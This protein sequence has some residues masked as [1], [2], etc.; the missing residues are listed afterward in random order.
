MLSGKKRRRLRF[1][2]FT[3]YFAIFLAA[4]TL[5][6]AVFAFVLPLMMTST[7]EDEHKNKLYEYT[8]NVA[9][10]YQNNINDAS[11]DEAMLVYALNGTSEASGADV[12]I[13]DLKGNVIYCS[14]MTADSNG[15]MNMDCEK[16]RNM[17]VPG[18]ITT[19]I[20]IDGMIATMGDFSNLND[21]V[22]FI[23][24]AVSK[25]NYAAQADAIVFAVQSGKEGLD[26]YYANFFEEY[27]IAALGF[28]SVTGLTVYVLTYKLVKIIKDMINATKRYSKGDFSCRIKIHDRSSVKEL[29]ELSLEINSMA[30]NLEQ[31]EKSRASF[32][33]NVSHEFKT[34][35]TTIG[36][37]VDGMIDGTIEENQ[38][39]YY[40]KI[41]S[42]EVKRLSR[43]VVAMLNM[44][45]MEAGEL[46]I[47]PGRYNLTQQIIGIFIA[48]EQK[49]NDKQINVA[50]LDLLEDI[51]INADQDMMNQVFYNLVD[52]A[53]KFT[54]QCGEIA[55]F[56]EVS[57]DDIVIRIRNT[58][59][60]INDEDLDHVFERFYK[61]D[62][63]RGLDAKSAGLGLHIVKSIVSLHGGEISVQNIDDKYTQFTV[64]L[65]RQFDD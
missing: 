21:E 22:S 47:N 43:L 6:L 13:T 1:S 30:E 44:S 23:S 27:V 29:D 46:K 65:S 50:G 53:V 5:S 51:Y 52:N 26:S 24:A 11:A 36:G 28:L 33:A 54:Q 56:S 62:K 17:R 20:L 16:H 14:H 7:W 59:K 35:M 49:I 64:R 58:G 3:R 32:V 41:V 34:P 8:V 39:R 38:H 37:F 18:E 31:L 45:K 19:S 63:S 2:L 4:E 9:Q 57:D 10:V 12:F 40:L 60:C 42:D 15:K 25:K 55:V 61:A 48:F